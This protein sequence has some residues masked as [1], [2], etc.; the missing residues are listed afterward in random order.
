M[1]VGIVVWRKTGQL[2]YSNQHAVTILGRSPAPGET[3]AVVM[4]RMVRAGTRT[5]YPPELV[6][7]ERIFHGDT[8]SFRDAEFEH[9]SGERRAVEGWTRSF[10]DHEG[11]VDGAVTTFIDITELRRT[12]ALRAGEARVLERVAADAPLEETL[13]TLARVFEDQADGMLAS[14]L[15][16]EGGVVRHAAAPSLPEPWTRLVDGQPIGPGRG[17]CGTAAYSRQPVI[18]TDI[19]SD[20]RWARYREPALALGFRACWSTPIL[21]NAGEVLGTFAFYY[22]EP[23]A[24]TARQLE[25]AAHAARLATVAIQSFRRKSALLGSVRDIT[26]QREA[27][28]DRLRMATR[29]AHIGVWSWDVRE[30]H[31]AWDEQ[32]YVLYGRTPGGQGLR[33]DEWKH[34]LHADDRAGVEAAL[35]AALRGEAPFDTEFRVAWPDGTL[36]HVKAHAVVERGADGA[37]LRVIGTN[38]D[39]TSAK[40]AEEQLRRAK[41]AAEAAT[42]ARSVFIAGM[43]HEMRTP[44]N[45]ILGYAQLLQKA[46]SLDEEQ[47][48]TVEVILSSGKSLLK[49]IN[50]VIESASTDAERATPAVEHERRSEPPA[51]VDRESLA[52]LAV[53]LPTELRASLR[54]AALDARAGRLAELAKLARE[55]SASAAAQLEKLAENFQYEIIAKAFESGRNS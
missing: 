17:S 31:I 36:R 55:H 48:R 35:Q 52:V 53:S 28:S 11:G 39:I 23:R 44:M 15:L 21:D 4:G 8:L 30:E 2:E 50:D 47:R 54:D 14:V 3:P 41:D 29:S 43:S 20:P 1:P 51:A 34:A 45:A 7:S 37:A 12:E 33:Y 38:W 24:P 42:R 18:V 6:L 19:A 10:C 25:L 9:A 32:M 5:S 49:L 46:S 13:A 27:L 40:L 16:V 22:S 26:H